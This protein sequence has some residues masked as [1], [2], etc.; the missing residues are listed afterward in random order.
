M[1]ILG[2][3][4]HID[5]G[6]SAVIKRL[7]GTDP[8]RL[9]EEKARGLTIDLGFAF[10]RTPGDETL[11]FIDVPGHERFVKNMIAGAGG[12]DAV[13]LVVAADDGW[14]PQSEE[15]FQVVRL[16]GVK[17]G[18]VVV[19]KIDLVEPDWLELLQQDIRQRLAGTFLAEAP[20][21]AVSAHTGEGFDDLTSYL[22][23][24]PGAIES[25]KDI[26][27]A[28]LYIDRSFVRA[29]IGGVV[30]GTLR[31]GSV[32]VGQTV[33]VWPGRNT[34][35]VR[36]LHSN[37]QEVQTARPGQ[38]TAMSFTGIDREHL[39]RGGAVSDRTDL[40]FFSR[41]PVLAL[42]VDLLP[43]A[44]VA[45]ADRRRVLCIV[46]TTEVEG[47]VR[48]YRDS[49]IRPGS[50][51]IVFFQPDDPAY[52]LVG[53]RYIMRLPTPMV[54]LGGGQVL[55]HLRHFPRR[56]HLDRYEYL[57]GRTTGRL[58]DLIL[59]ELRKRVL[60]PL[61][62]LLDEADFAR[63][64]IQQVA[65]KLRGEKRASLFEN[66][67]YEPATIDATVEY[68]C[69]RL[70]TVLERKSHLK[71]V[72]LERLLQFSPYDRKTSEI[73]MRYALDRG[74]I[75]RHGDEYTP[76]GREMSLKGPV[77]NAYEDIMSRLRADPWSPPKLGDFT[78]RGK[79]YKEAVGYILDASEGHKCGAD[80][81]FLQDTWT[82]IVRYIKE[83][84]NTRNE[85]AVSDLR[86]HF[87]FTRKYVIPILEETDRL[88]LTRR[89]GDV[90]VKG[91]R[92]EA[93]EFNL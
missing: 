88:K 57:A 63:S 6:K 75:A 42:S 5:H 64:D 81:V 10:Y 31:G 9:P 24:L 39:V 32:S 76:A 1:L 28:R 38:R 43:D 80:F 65:K 44:P 51:G 84:L 2:T 11:A 14:M 93:E 68:I 82:E 60:V 67:L 19:N 86:D 15:H 58:D 79:A 47:E 74:V 59:S 35:K 85:L 8:D 16:L 4:G 92:F 69:K 73:L 91:E 3:A 89:E 21:F 40:D 20:I 54:T 7:T 66:Y 49:Q 33:G 22:N 72:P 29:G 90:R 13:M 61:N 53:D 12:I 87:G 70:A 37:N 18:L 55:D 17:H 27:K 52:C 45:L 46:G 83:Q 34:A 41:H 62:A 48:L 77:K 50:G 25:R 71:G 30:T 78:A 23:T 26:G 36:S 56:R